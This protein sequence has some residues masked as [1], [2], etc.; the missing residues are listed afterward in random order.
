MRFKHSIE[1]LSLM[2]PTDYEEYGMESSQ[3]AKIVEGA[4]H[5]SYDSESDDSE[6]IPEVK[7]GPEEI[8]LLI[9]SLTGDELSVTIDSQAKVSELKHA[10]QNQRSDFD[11]EK[12]ILIYFGRRLSDNSTIDEYGIQ[13]KSSLNLIL[14]S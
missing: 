10:I 12:Q 11:A 2:Q 1:S 7:F 9:T 3:G 5:V 8:E 6:L 13:S 14:K 4:Q